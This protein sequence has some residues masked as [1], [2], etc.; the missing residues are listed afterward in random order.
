MPSRRDANGRFTRTR[1]IWTPEDWD[2]GYYDNRGRVRV[3]RPDYPRAYEGGYALRSHV[4][5]WLKTGTIHPIEFDIHHINKIVD[6]DRFENLEAIE[7]SQH[8]RF[9]NSLGDTTLICEH[10]QQ[11][12]AVPV[13]K[14]NSRKSEGLKIRFC[15][16]RCYHKH[17]RSKEHNKAMGRSLKKAHKRKPNWRG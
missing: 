10:C 13:R 8:S 3:Y 4:V 16:Q 7:H 5:W 2:N 14:F 15:S 9:H 1:E 11:E 17:P 6:D 12:F